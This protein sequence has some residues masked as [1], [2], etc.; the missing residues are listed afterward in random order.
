MTSQKFSHIEIFKLTV[1]TVYIASGFFMFSLL[2][3]NASHEFVE[4]QDIIVEQEWIDCM[5]CDE[6]D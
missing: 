2:I 5:N 4:S 1:N 6:I 3:S